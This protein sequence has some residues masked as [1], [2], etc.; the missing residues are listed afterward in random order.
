MALIVWT[1]PGDASV[2]ANWV[3]GVAPGVGDTARL[4]N[5]NDMTIDAALN[6]GGLGMVGYTGTMS[7]DNDLDIDG[8][9]T[10][11]GTIDGAANIEVEA[12]ITA[13][14]GMTMS[15]TGDVIWN[16][17]GAVFIQYNAIQ[18][19]LE[20]NGS[21]IL[22]AQDASF[23]SSLAV[24]S[25]TYNASSYAHDMTGNIT[26]SGTGSLNFNT[27]NIDLNTNTLNGG[28][29]ANQLNTSAQVHDGTVQN[30]LI[31]SDNNKLN[32]R[33]NCAKSG[34]CSRVTWI[35]RP[36]I[37]G[38]LATVGELIQGKIS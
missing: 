13:T 28:S 33:T 6:W 31:K 36:M 8:D 5:A 15:L 24:S 14:A 11:D 2:G 26:I 35:S 21:S 32:C 7:V 4:N 10:F 1:G 20:V 3:G 23:L 34:T 16:G 27:S 12:Y 19:P 18:I 25:G 37:D 30:L 29:I 17:S 22:T 9:A 38:S